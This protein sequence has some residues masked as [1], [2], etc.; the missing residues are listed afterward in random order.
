M[1]TFYISQHAEDAQVAAAALFALSHALSQRGALTEARE[2]A[3]RAA[4]IRDGGISA[5]VGQS[6]AILGESSVPAG[7]E[8]DICEAYLRVASL[9]E[10][11][12]DF[13]MAV[14]VWFECRADFYK[15]IE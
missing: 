12:G 15:K 5:R 9:S 13:E 14:E 4:A 10:Q 6:A 2:C 8:R 1:C 3:R 11:L 7:T